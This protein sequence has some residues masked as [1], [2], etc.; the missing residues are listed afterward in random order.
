MVDD[1]GDDSAASIT[2]VRLKS[3]SITSVN[4]DGG[5]TL[6]PALHG[7]FS[8]SVLVLLPPHKST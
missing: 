7:D 4:N 3:L 2:M 6:F 1:L 8:L 5:L